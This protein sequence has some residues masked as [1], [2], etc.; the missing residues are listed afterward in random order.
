MTGDGSESWLSLTT[1]HVRVWRFFPPSSI[2]GTGVANVLALVTKEKGFPQRIKLDNGP[3]F[4]SKG[5][6]RWA[7]T[8]NAVLDYSRPGK[9]SDNAFIEAFNSRFR[10]ECLNEYWS[11]SLDDAREKIEAWRLAYNFKFRLPIL[12]G[13]GPFPNP[14]RSPFHRAI[15]RTKTY[16]ILSILIRNYVN[17]WHESIK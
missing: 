6:D 16:L 8:N 14:S 13:N 3:E 15:R 11:L 4:I 9:P 1:T 10:Q 17:S 5:V 7:Y 2:R 12:S